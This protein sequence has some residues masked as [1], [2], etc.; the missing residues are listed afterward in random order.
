MNRM[1]WTAALWI[2]LI[3]PRLT[4][5]EGRVEYID[6]AKLRSQ[7]Q[8]LLE[9]AQEKGQTT[10][11]ETLQ[12]QL[13]R[14]AP[15]SLK[16]PPPRRHQ[17]ELSELY[18]TCA[19]SV[20]MVGQLYKCP[21]CS[22]WHIAT[23]SGFVI[24]TNGTMVTNY[25]VVKSDGKAK[26]DST[27]VMGAMSRD[28]RFFPVMEVLACSRRDD[29]AL[30]RLGGEGFKALP[31]KSSE[32]VGTAIAVISHPDNS[33]FMLTSGII[34]RYTLE[35][36]SQN[37]S[38]TQRRM[39]IT[40]EYAKGS[41]GAPVLDLCGNVVGLASSTVSIYYDTNHGTQENLQQVMKY[42]IPA[43]CIQSLAQ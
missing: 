4:A 37:M 25:H 15:V 16:L 38:A 10:T 33:Y 31:V 20:L 17:L 23:A 40:A 1:I 14:K 6:D 42:C 13:T 39:M 8:A 41:S 32:P 34:S 5:A 19:D 28:G 9:R 2:A 35:P 22:H 24:A 26:P 3:V 30:L 18:E 12:T 36:E 27:G 11:T 29:V 7:L 43:E 21:R